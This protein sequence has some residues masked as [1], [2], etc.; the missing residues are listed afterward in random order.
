M[1]RAEQHSPLPPGEGQGVRAGRDSCDSSHSWFLSFSIR[2][3]RVSPR[4]A[5]L[6]ATFGTNRHLA[7]RAF[8]RQNSRLAH[9]GTKWH[10]FRFSPMQPPT[11]RRAVRQSSRH[12]PSCRPPPNRGAWFVGL[13]HRTLSI[14]PC[15]LNI[16]SL[17]LPR[18]L[19]Q[20]VDACQ[21]L[22]TTVARFRS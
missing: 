17:F 22:L 13:D 3:H 8:P 20:M 1:R 7:D 4:I 19:Y 18:P 12:A 2:F 15:T 21:E 16:T 14:E 10:G 5:P 9:F 6:L 11:L